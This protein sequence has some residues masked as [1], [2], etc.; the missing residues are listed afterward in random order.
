MDH[1]VPLEPREKLYGKFR[2]FV[3]STDDQ[4]KRGRITAFVPE[5][6]GDQ[7]TGWAEPCVPYGGDGSGFFSV[8][9]PRSR[10]WIEFEAGDVSRP[11]WTG[12]YWGVGEAPIPPPSGP[13]GDQNRKIWRSDVGLTVV[14]DDTNERIT[15]TDADG[16]NKVEISITSGTVTI[17]GK[18]KIIHD[19]K[20]VKV[21]SDSA[22]HPAAFGDNLLAYLNQLVLTFNTHSH[23]GELAI[24]VLPV[25]P[26]PPVKPMQPPK[27]SLLSR[28]VFVE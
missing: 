21:G 12:C 25:T 24:G 28:K 15:L 27:P 10:V 4:E 2:G 16:N 13:L 14:L 18:A 9:R 8:P 6:L 23:P 19:S 5:V 7:P 20:V 17:K 1:P 22:G 3:D 11:I 26:T